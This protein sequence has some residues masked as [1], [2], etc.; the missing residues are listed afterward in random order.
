MLVISQEG[1]NQL[2]QYPMKVDTWSWMLAISE[3]GLNQL[4][5]YPMKVDTWSWMLV[6]SEEGLNQL[7]QYPMKVDTWSWMLLDAGDFGGRVES[8]ASEESKLCEVAVDHDTNEH[9]AISVLESSNTSLISHLDE[10]MSVSDSEDD[11]DSEILDDGYYSPSSDEDSRL[12]KKVRSPRSLVVGITGSC[13]VVESTI[14]G[15]G[16]R[17]GSQD[18]GDE[19]AEISKIETSNLSELSCLDDLLSANDSGNDSDSAIFDEEAKSKTEHETRSNRGDAHR[20]GAAE[21]AEELS[22]MRSV[23]LAELT[24]DEEDQEMNKLPSNDSSIL[25]HLE[26]IV[27]LASDTDD[28]S[29]SEIIDDG[30]Y[31]SEG[32]LSLDASS[33]FDDSSMLSHLHYLCASDASSVNSCSDSLD[34]YDYFFE[35]DG[36]EDNNHKPRVPSLNVMG[37]EY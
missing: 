24:L 5:Q 8:V 14:Q 18:R 32:E 17:R 16:V 28:D 1:L 4:R 9:T 15:L 25:S 34:D 37:R 23:V 21:A 6:I 35:S 7:R 36:E 20:R 30:Y 27:S 3:E 29:G 19:F 13:S 33:S 10:L 26:E 2:R 11:S 31:S 12:F 22:E